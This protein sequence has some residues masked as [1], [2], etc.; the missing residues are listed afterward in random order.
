MHGYNWLMPQDSWHF[1]A[2]AGERLRESPPSAGRIQGA[3]RRLVRLDLADVTAN[4]W[5]LADPEFAAWVR[6]ADTGAS[7]ERSEAE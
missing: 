4:G 7:R 1:R 3:L 5:M 2:A 6:E